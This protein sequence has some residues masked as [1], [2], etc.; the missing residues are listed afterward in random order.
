M[1]VI[2][3]MSMTDFVFWGGAKDRV[4]M[5]S[6][7]DLEQLTYIIEDI[8]PEGIEDTFLNDL[9]WFDFGVVCEWLGYEYN[10]EKDEIIREEYVNE[11]EN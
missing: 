6:Y 5:L 11:E 4:K 3:E 1:K 8:Y 7:T 2:N 10:E 9:L